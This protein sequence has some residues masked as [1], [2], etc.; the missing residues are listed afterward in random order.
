MSSKILSPEELI[1]DIRD[2][3]ANSYHAT[4]TTVAHA[5]L[6]KYIIIDSPKIN[7]KEEEDFEIT[8]D[9][10]T[11]DGIRANLDSYRDTPY[12]LCEAA[13]D[14]REMEAVEEAYED[15]SVVSNKF[16]ALAAKLYITANL[17]L[18]DAVVTVSEEGFTFNSIPHHERSQYLEMAKSALKFV[19][20]STPKPTPSTPD[21]NRT[22]PASPWQ[23][24]Q[25]R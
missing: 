5:L 10:V 23:G 13:D 16:K 20:D 14:Y 24:I 18:V 19:E 8:A 9:G 17:G 11:L 1:A 3:I 4:G 22:A 2:I 21:F 15:F 25:G 6:Q 12:R 7:Y